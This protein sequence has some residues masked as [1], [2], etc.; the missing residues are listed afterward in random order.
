MSKQHIHIG[1]ED[2]E[3]GYKRFIKAWHK[4]E[5]NKIEQTEI[6]LNFEDFS[7]LLATLTT[8]RLELLKSLRQ[9]G[10]MSVRALAKQLQ[11]DYKNVHTD[12]SALEEIN[13]IIRTDEDLITAPWDVIDTHLQLVA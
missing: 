13:L 9:N 10:P 1:V 8:K 11:R 3:R 2:S 12:V 4:A 7:I 6:H 5:N